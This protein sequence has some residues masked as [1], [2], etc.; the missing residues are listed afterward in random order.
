[1]H[2]LSQMKYGYGLYVSTLKFLWAAAQRPQRPGTVVVYMLQVSIVTSKIGPNRSRSTF[3]CTHSSLQ[4]FYLFAII[5]V[6]PLLPR[7]LGYCS[8]FKS[9]QTLSTAETLL[10]SLYAGYHKARYN[11]KQCLLDKEQCTHLLTLSSQ[12]STTFYIKSKQNE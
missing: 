1:M 7:R 8:V 4:P 5:S 2:V 11:K 9:F 6:L 3:S 12:T 10:L